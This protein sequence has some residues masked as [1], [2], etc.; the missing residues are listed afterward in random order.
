MFVFTCVYVCLLDC[1][2]EFLE[3]ENECFHFVLHLGLE[4]NICNKIMQMNDYLMAD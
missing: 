1:F 4:N 3:I 2:V